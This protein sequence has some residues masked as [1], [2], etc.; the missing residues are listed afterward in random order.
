MAKKKTDSKKKK[1]DEDK[2]EELFDEPGI[3]SSMSSE[4]IRGIIGVFL[5]V[6]A[7]LLILSALGLAGIAGDNAFKGI[8]HIVGIGYWLVPVLLI[9]LAW[10][11]FRNGYDQGVLRSIRSVGAIGFFLSVLGLIDITL[12]DDAAGKLGE[13]LV[14]PFIHYLDTIATIVILVG[15][16]IISLLLLFDAELW[17]LIGNKI[18]GLFRKK[19]ALEGDEYDGDEE[20]EELEEEGDE[21]EEYEEG[22]EEE[23]YEEDEYELSEVKEKKGKKKAKEKTFQLPSEY[24]APPLSLLEGDKGT[25][26]TGGDTKIRANVIKKTLQHFKIPVEMDEVVVGPT[27]T[28][29]S[30]KPAAG[31]K[32]NKIVALQSNL[33]LALAASPIRIEA[34]IPGKSLVGI[35]VP[36]TGKSIVGLG[37]LVSSPEFSEET[38]PLFVTL[39]KDIAGSAHY[40]NIGK[41]PHLLV[42]GT[43]GSG[44]SVMIHSIITSLLYRN[45]P[46]RIRFIMVD[47]KRVELTLYN[48]IPHLLTP[49]ITEAK[50]CILSLKWAAKEMDRRYDILQEN[51]V[52]DIGGYHNKVVAPAHAKYEK[53]KSK[54][55]DV[56]EM[57]MPEPMP[58]IVIVIDELA[59]IMN[60]Y[61]RELEG[62]IV[63][64]AQMSR[65]VGIHLILSTQRPEVKVI[66]GLIK[67]NIPTRIALKVQSIIDSRTI[68]DQPG[69]EKLLGAGDMLYLAADMA[70]PRRIQSPFLTT[71]EVNKVVSYIVKNNEMELDASMDFSDNDGNGESAGIPFDRIE[72][73]DDL[74]DLYE[75]VRDFIVGEGKASTSLIQRKFR[76]GYGRAARI[77][78]QLEQHGVISASDGTNK[79]R[80]V[81]DGHHEEEEVEEEEYEEEHTDD[82]EEDE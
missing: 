46:E 56:S 34:P 39:G 48:S 82:Y 47:P 11:L 16:L 29:Y 24:N 59:D 18:L 54:G 61:P 70:K 53:R 72:E 51:K 81:I 64:L 42:A 55:K 38:V 44:K 4:T 31:I 8:S 75:E 3:F 58:H 77:M 30:L 43:T 6:V 21:E 37:G 62:A 28:R 41:M 35:E 33:E 26:N 50:K 52:Q 22:D 12:G 79:P 67:A 13:Y 60:A 20:H 7:I 19:D 80:T 10:S 68:L 66:T 73:D 9:G 65:A 45:G 40:A 36:N 27:V 32:L 23:E 49:V 15:T 71:A 25:V 17:I 1:K 74:D 78:D 69:A 2:D 57:E 14:M 5:F 76:V 63:R